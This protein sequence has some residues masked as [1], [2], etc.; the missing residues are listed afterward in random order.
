[1]AKELKLGKMT[2]KEIA[3]W[4][5]IKINSFNHNKTNKL[6]E[7]ENFADFEV[8]YG[9]INIINIYEPIYFKRSSM[10]YQ[11]IK[12]NFD[13]AWHKSG[14]DTAARV[15]SQIWIE[16]PQ[17]QDMIS[18]TTARQYACRIRKEFYGLVYK[19]N[20]EGTKGTCHSKWVA[21]NNWDEAV[22]LSKE[23]EKQLKQTIK[24]I[25]AN[26]N[27]PLLY[28]ALRNHEITEQEYQE[29]LDEWNSSEAR[30][31]RYEK[32]K[33]SLIKIFGFMPEKVTE[34][35]KGL[36]FGIDK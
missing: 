2:T 10:A 36:N 24:D 3:E 4:F 17:I 9:G 15:G 16:N 34:L 30:Q 27:E 31:H 1:M 8:E 14:L 28:T 26:E 13:Q 32:F 29:A 12:D 20:S 35:I 25:Y 6:K 22:L 11:V 33:A 7:L 18:E 5:G 23:Q 21:E 19:Q